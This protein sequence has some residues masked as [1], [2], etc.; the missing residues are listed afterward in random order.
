MNKEDKD[1]IISLLMEDDKNDT[2]EEKLDTIIELLIDL[3]EEKDFEE[4]LTNTGIP[5]GL[6]YKRDGKGPRGEGPKTGRGLGNCC[7]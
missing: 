1:L 5:K 6:F 4:P 2:I 7:Q 3:L